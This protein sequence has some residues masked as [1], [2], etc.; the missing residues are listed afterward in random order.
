[1]ATSV[2]ISIYFNVDI[3]GA[4]FPEQTSADWMGEVLT[5]FFIAGGSSGAL[6]LFQ[7]H[8]GWAKSLRDAKLSADKATAETE[9]LVAKMASDEAKAKA[10]RAEMAAREAKAKAERA[11]MATREAKTKRTQAGAAATP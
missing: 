7:S 1:M 8:L 5:G 4:L 3:L 9:K 6:A 11:E 10:E 2:A